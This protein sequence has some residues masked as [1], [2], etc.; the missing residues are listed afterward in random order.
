MS[1]GEGPRY[2]DITSESA[3]LSAIF[4]KGAEA[5]LR[6]EDY[7]LT[8][9]DFYYETNQN[10]FFV[11][12]KIIQENPTARIDKAGLMAK[13]HMLG[14]DTFVKKAQNNDLIEGICII[15]VNVESVPYLCESVKRNSVFRIVLDD[16][17]NLSTDIEDK[18]DNN[19]SLEDLLFLVENKTLSLTDAIVNPNA[20]ISLMGD[21]YKEWIKDLM[22]NPRQLMGI[23]TG[24]NRYDVSI[25]GG[26][27]RQSINLIGA[28]PKVG[29]SFI[30]L[31]VA[32]NVASRNIPVLYLDTELTKDHQLPRFGALNANIPISEIETGRLRENPAY[33]QNMKNSIK[34]I[35][36]IPLCHEYIG[37]WK[38]E[39]IITFVKMWINKFVGFD[40]N[41][42]VKDCLIVYD[43]L[44]M[45]RDDDLGKMQEYQR[46]GFLITQLQDLCVRQDVAMFMLIQL[47]RDG[48]EQESSNVIS[49]SDR[50]LWNVGS[51]SILKDKAEDEM[52]ESG[53]HGNKKLIVKDARFG[54]G[55]PDSYINMRA[56]LR[57]AKI[58]E[59]LTSRE[60]W[61]EDRKSGQPET[62]KEDQSRDS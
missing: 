4:N 46:I 8:A 60:A 40:E 48:A 37:G 32:N 58:S 2:T 54:T 12:E 7:G 49:Q 33:I 36:S 13:A 11:M 42:N 14:L 30:A 59:G 34:K 45:L 27:R 9:K 29:K 51:F 55:T 47:N 38:F 21:G 50:V 56:D 1:I 39:Q 62:D 35:E 5:Y 15:P 20:K 25:G 18:I 19:A 22:D 52:V 61:N 28:R 26:L 23:P 3:I 31:N 6:T 53:V 16:I 10:L 57:F 24:Y 17:R 43:Y 44:K 41:G